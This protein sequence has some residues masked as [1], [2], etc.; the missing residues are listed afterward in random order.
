[1]LIM[2]GLTIKTIDGGVTFRTKIVPG[3]SKTAFSGL[4]DGMLKVKISAPPEKGKANKSLLKFL[5]KQLSVKTNAISIT[6]GHTNPV[7]TVQVLGLS[8][9]ILINKLNLNKQDH[10]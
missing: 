5:A 4:L 8:A 2:A 9:E 3:S 1:M 7:K 10:S 6:A